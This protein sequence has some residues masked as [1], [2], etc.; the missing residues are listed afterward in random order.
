MPHNRLSFVRS[1]PFSTLHQSGLHREVIS[2]GVSV[3]TRWSRGE[4]QLN[5]EPKLSFQPEIGERTLKKGST[6]TGREKEGLHPIQRQGTD[7][8]EREDPICGRSSS[9]RNLLRGDMKEKIESGD[10]NST[11]E[12]PSGRAGF[13]P[14]V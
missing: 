6:A 8:T 1:P 10:D 14:M 4:H 9:Y 2:I 5:S 12:I 13:N 11:W 3:E 7:Y